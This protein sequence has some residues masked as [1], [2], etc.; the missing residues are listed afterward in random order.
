MMAVRGVGW[1]QLLAAVSVGQSQAVTCQEILQ[2]FKKSQVLIRRNCTESG[3]S[4]P[5]PPYYTCELNGSNK[6]TE[7]KGAYFAT[8]KVLYTC[9]YSTSL[10][11]LVL[12]ISIFSCFRKLHCTRN[13]I[14]INFF[15]SFI[16]RG[17]AVFIKDSVLF[18]DE[19][20][21]HCTMSTVNCKVAIAFFQY[22]VLANF[23]WLLVEGMY[24]QTLL[25]F[26]FIS[27]KRYFWWYTLIGWGE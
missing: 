18:A 8:V 19:S 4:S 1:R 12:A 24:L 23:Y 7:A 26:T 25:L 9:G 22:S 21:N 5:S 13:S 10:A 16:M 3:W 11:A 14:H 15:S 20:I 6:D 2:V 27:D 17:A